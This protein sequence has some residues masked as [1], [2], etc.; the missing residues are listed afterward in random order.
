MFWDFKKDNEFRQ[1]YMCDD[2]LPE[3][4]SL[5]ICYCH[6]WISNNLQNVDEYLKGLVNRFL[7]MRNAVVHESFPV[8]ILPSYEGKKTAQT[9]FLH[10]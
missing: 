7:E 9:H 2:K 6:D 10:Q 8:M 1:T 5:N 3:F 4:C